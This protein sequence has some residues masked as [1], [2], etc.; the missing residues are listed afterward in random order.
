M[1]IMTELGHFS[2][3]LIVYEIERNQPFYAI[4]GQKLDFVKMTDLKNSLKL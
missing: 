4:K 2:L 1:R 3:I